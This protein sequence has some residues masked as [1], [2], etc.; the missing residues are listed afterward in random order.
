MNTPQASN[1]NTPCATS[2]FTVDFVVVTAFP[3]EKSKL[4]VPL[5][6][7]LCPVIAAPVDDAKMKDFVAPAL[8]FASAYRTTNVLDVAV[9]VTFAALTEHPLPHG[10]DGVERPLKRYSVGDDEPNASATSAFAMELPGPN[11]THPAPC[12]SCAP[13]KTARTRTSSELEPATA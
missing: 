10:V 9:D 1:I 7:L 13:E 11:A 6:E 3:V 8:A 5:L 4:T 2:R 12:G